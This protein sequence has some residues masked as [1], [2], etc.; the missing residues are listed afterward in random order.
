MSTVA[1]TRSVAMHAYAIL[2][3]YVDWGVVL[4]GG[5]FKGTGIFHQSSHGITMH[6]YGK[7]L[8]LG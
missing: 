6:N 5:D 1:N 3:Y 4:G 2:E 7:Q 8:T